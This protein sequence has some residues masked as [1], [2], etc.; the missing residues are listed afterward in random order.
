MK[1]IYY[2]LIIALVLMI[3]S[4]KARRTT[5]ESMLYDSIDLSESPHNINPF[6]TIGE[7]IPIF[8]NMYLSVEISSL[9]DVADVYYSAELLNSIGKTSDY[10]TSDQKATNLGVYAVDLSYAKVFDQLE[11]A[12]QYLSAMQQLAL[13]MG[14]PSKY[15]TGIISR[16]ENNID[17]RDSIMSIANDV[18]YDVNNYLNENERY[19]TSA[20][21]IMGGWVEAMHIASSVIE[22]S[23]NPEIFERYAEQKSSIN[24]L[25]SL[26]SGHKDNSVINE[27]INYLTPIKDKLNNLDINF[28][29]TEDSQALIEKYRNEIKNISVDIK[30]IRKKIVT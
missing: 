7:G 18:Y 10:I 17:N 19:S 2:L 3:T 29:D 21:V 12:G 28:E 22:E 14:I 8:Y 11:V 1:N 6:D 5:T 30:K 13:E 26:L 23:Q 15:F 24:N 27:Y 4:C 16:F 20:L 9:F 25:I